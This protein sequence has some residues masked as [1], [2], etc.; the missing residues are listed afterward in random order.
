MYN[1]LSLSSTGAEY[2]AVEPIFTRNFLLT[3]AEQYE[4]DGGDRWTTN[5]TTGEEATE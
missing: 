2:T 1:I 3:D 4:L 5:G